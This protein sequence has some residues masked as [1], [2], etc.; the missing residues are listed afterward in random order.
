MNKTTL[1]V[2]DGELL[3]T[4]IVK[5]GKVATAKQIEA[6]AKGTW[7]YQQTH[8]RIQQ[9]IK[10][11]WLVRI[12]RGL[13]AVNDLSSR[14]FISVSP[15]VIAGLLVEDSYVSFEAALN[16]YGM[17]DQFV[18]QFISVS[19]KQYKTTDLE[20]IQYRFIKTQENFFVGWEQVE[21]ENMTA[22]IASAEKALI[23]LI[24]FRTGKYVVDLVIEK[25]QTYKEDLNI[26]KLVHYASLASQKTVKVF[27]L[28]FDLLS[29]N[30]NELSQ[31]VVNNRSTHW[32]TA[33]DKI[34]NAKWR[35]YYNEYFNNYQ[36]NKAK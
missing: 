15:Y 25:L 17:F 3:E 32:I 9:L 21:I 35:L 33:N 4:L 34:F 23:D 30:S 26:G 5:Y 28:I 18:Q 6:E 27:G 11:G 12:K 14:G 13:Y 24:H 8:N 19:L 31:Y 36:V 16:F 22:K 2:K 29:W 20:S 10:N 1:A 7:D